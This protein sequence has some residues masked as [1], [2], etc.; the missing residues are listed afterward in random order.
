MNA[1]ETDEKINHETTELYALVTL[2]FAAQ[3][4]TYYIPV[5]EEGCEALKYFMGS[6]PNF[7]HM[8][9]DI[10]FGDHTKTKLKYIKI[11]CITRGL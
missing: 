2:T 11:G 9:P 10:Y 4:C 7:K 6:L 1:K 5:K 3:G 8:Y